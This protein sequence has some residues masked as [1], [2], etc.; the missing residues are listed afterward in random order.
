MPIPSIEHREEV[1]PT[2]PPP[3][4]LPFTSSPPFGMRDRQPPE[5]S[6][7]SGASGYG[8][9]DSNG[10]EERPEF[11]R[12]DTASTIGDEGYASY[13]TVDR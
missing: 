3:R 13:T 2:L 10:A 1:P 8:S 12:R 7:R 11:E 9:M 6:L 4:I 5:Y